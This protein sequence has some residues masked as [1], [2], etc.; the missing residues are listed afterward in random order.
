MPRLT[1][2]R[3]WPTLLTGLGV[4]L[5]LVTALEWVAV[6][7]FSADAAQGYVVGIL[8][9]LPFIAGLAYAG[10][11]LQQSGLPEDQYSRIGT[12]TLVGL[13]LFLGTNVAL[14][15]ALPP[16]S[17]VGLVSWLRWAAALGA[18]VGLLVGLFEAQAVT[19]ERRAERA[20]Y[21]QRELQR[22]NERL[23]EFASIVSHDLRNPL[24]VA[25]GRLELEIGRAHV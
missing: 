9:S 6:V 2:V 25:Q 17:H 23:D 20:Q 11:W 18:G 10:V 19:N 12:R 8:T 5:G 3:R 7:A 21:R 14:V 24:N 1:P 22:Q 4:L 15:V 16:A 13:A